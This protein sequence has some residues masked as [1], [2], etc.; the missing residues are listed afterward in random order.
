MLSTKPEDLEAQ[1]AA[2]TDMAEKACVCV[3]GPKSVLEGFGDLEI[4]EL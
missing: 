4:F 3:V 1:K 2:L